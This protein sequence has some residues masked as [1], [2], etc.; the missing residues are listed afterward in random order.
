[1]NLP[2]PT[3][4]VAASETGDPLLLTPGPLT[5][6][7]AVK[8]A[9]LHDYGSRDQHFIDINRRMLSRLVSIVHGEDDFVAVP[10]QGSGTFVVEAMI[11]CFVPPDGK[12]LLCVNG[13]YGKRM[14]KICQYHRP[15]Q[16]S[17]RVR[18]KR[19]GGAR[20]D[21]SCAGGR[22]RNHPCRGGSQRD[23]FRHSESPGGDRGRWLRGMNAA[24]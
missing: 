13:A 3:H 18:R 21:R 1:M 17:A 23:H 5:T 20:L 12:L 9:M 4:R 6:S 7:A 24:C 16:L 2:Q 8:R 15:G 22:S 11:G 10:L 14:A 19:T